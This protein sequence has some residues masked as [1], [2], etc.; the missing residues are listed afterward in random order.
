M[1]KLPTVLLVTS[2]RLTSLLTTSGLAMYGYEVRTAPSPGQ[3][4]EMMQAALTGGDRIGVLM[5]D[6]DLG[7]E[8]DG[9]T[10]AKLARTLNPKLLVIYTTRTPQRVSDRMKV[11]G[12]PILRTPYHAQ[13]VAGVIRE[14]QQGP[15]PGQSNPRA[16]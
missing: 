4:L 8:P 7:G 9:Y 14:L 11:P 6:L 15:Q 10:V 5:I 3:G 16:A 1:Y 13:Q 12:A 2:D